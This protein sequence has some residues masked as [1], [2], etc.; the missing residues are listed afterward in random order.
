MWKWM[1]GGKK[2]ADVK[3]DDA[4]E[5]DISLE[6]AS[7][8]GSESDVDIG[9][10]E[11]N[12]SRAVLRQLRDLRRRHNKYAETVDGLC[13]KVDE[14]VEEFHPVV[15]S[16][17]VDTDEAGPS[18]SSRQSIAHQL[19]TEMSKL[20]DMVKKMDTKTS[21]KTTEM[22]WNM[23]NEYEDTFEADYISA[24]R[25][26]DHEALMKLLHDRD[27]INLDVVGAD[28]KFG[29]QIALENENVEIAT[30]LFNRGIKIGV[31]LLRLI[32]LDCP[33]AVALICNHK[34]IFE[35]NG[36]DIFGVH[37]TDDEFPVETTAIILAARMN[38]FQILKILLKFGAVMPTLEEV[39]RN[40]DNGRPG[41]ARAVFHLCEAFA[42]E[43]YI[44]Q[45][46]DDMLRDVF[47]TTEKIREVR[48]QEKTSLEERGM[49]DEYTLLEE[50]LEE[51]ELRILNLVNGEEME[52]LLNGDDPAA[53]KKFTCCLNVP[54]NI[55]IR[56]CQA[57]DLKHK[58]FIAHSKSQEY[59][60]GRWRHGFD[61]HMNRSS[62]KRSLA[63][64]CLGTLWPILGIIY[65]IC[66]GFN[67]CSTF[68]RLMR[69]PYVKFIFYSSSRIVLLLILTFQMLDTTIFT[70]S[71]HDTSEELE[72]AY[73][74]YRTHTSL[75][76]LIV[77][78]WI[79]GMT[80]RELSDMCRQGMRMYGR[81]GWSQ[82]EIPQLVLYW[83]YMIFNVVAYV[84][85]MD[86]N[87][88]H[89][90]VESGEIAKLAAKRNLSDLIPCDVIQ[91]AESEAN[92]TECVRFISLTPKI[93]E[94][95]SRL[96]WYAYEPLLIAEAAFAVA[97]VLTFVRL[98]DATVLVA[99][100][101]I[102]QVSFMQMFRAVIKFL[103]LY[104]FI[105]VSFALGLTQL[106]RPYE[107]VKQ[108]H[109]KEQTDELECEETHF[110][111]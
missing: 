63:T 109:C 43:A 20:K 66:S 69:C 35:A 50:R 9:D 106:Y 101:G 39:R 103:C 64:L 27:D 3:N 108:K 60:W 41:R 11:D 62:L 8:A 6:I 25:R 29:V 90:T 53:Y 92:E 104:T 12:L 95:E 37:D 17:E 51:M 56:L 26:N 40:F 67:C 46:S 74:E 94:L 1:L 102:L 49:R 71:S 48:R 14:L 107:H 34:R 85:E 38:R 89:T 5:D 111:T 98:L 91:L 72:K 42:S 83:I 81:I 24:I 86:S 93:G 73:I 82:I 36:E 77:W 33:A 75:H 15:E 30:L 16:T 52:T 10:E 18:A 13:K 59:I 68:K 88:N 44:L 84:Q 55:P 78:I 100:L 31:T 65:L 22:F 80:W 70:V 57:M 2:T 99:P 7:Q 79:V 32:E 47:E 19:K 23:T 61:E 21:N 96:D 87:C 58:K 110:T 4:N 28:G 97:N 76:P 45:T 54:E 105:W